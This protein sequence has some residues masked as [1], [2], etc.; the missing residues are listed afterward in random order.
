MNT[1]SLRGRPLKGA[2]HGVVLF[3]ALIML[4][5]MSIAGIGLMRSV[6]GGVLLAGNLSLKQ[7]TTRVADLGYEAARDWVVN[8][9]S[10][11]DREANVSAEGYIATGLADFDPIAAGDAFWNGPAVRTLAPA[12]PVYADFTIRYVV[13]RLCE[14]NGALDATGQRCAHHATPPPVCSSPLGCGSVIRALYRV[15]TRVTGPKGTDSY[16]QVVFY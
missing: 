7:A 13:H 11:A 14:V 9:A 12:D 8:G 15:T 16:V 10:A 6:G 5:A 1:S 3:I 2:Q 4:V